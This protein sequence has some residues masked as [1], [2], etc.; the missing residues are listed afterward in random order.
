MS[1]SHAPP[2]IARD[3]T[4]YS[5]KTLRVQDEPHQYHGFMF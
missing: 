2:R 1:P 4:G 5:L 3:T